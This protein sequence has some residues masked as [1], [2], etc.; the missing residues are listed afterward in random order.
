MPSIK[1]SLLLAAGAIFV[2]NVAT[3]ATWHETDNKGLLYYT[4]G[5]ASTGQL[6]L[7]CDPE[8]LWAGEGEKQSPQ[9]F[10]FASL[11]NERIASDKVSITATDYSAT[12]S[13]E[14]GAIVASGDSEN[15]NKL[16]SALSAK[17][18][19]NV[20]AAGKQFS[21]DVDQPLQSRCAILTK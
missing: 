11:N 3:A 6:T 1:K 12:L 20:N 16:V 21:I 19:V 5:N 15:W 17:G 4:I 2:G 7:V 10:V 9:F 14:G 8:N 13:N 18:P